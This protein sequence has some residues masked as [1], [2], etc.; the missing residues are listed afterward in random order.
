MSPIISLLPLL[1]PPAVPPAP[2][3]VAHP[4]SCECA[5]EAHSEDDTTA[6]A[7]AVEGEATDAS[8]DLEAGT[9]EPAVAEDPFATDDDLADRNRKL[10]Q[11]MQQGEQKMIL[12]RI[13]VAAGGTLFL[14]GLG[15]TVAGGVL[16]NKPAL[17]VGI[18]L[19]LIGAAGAGVST[20][21]AIRGHREVKEAQAGNLSFW[22]DRNG[23]GIVWSGRF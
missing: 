1:A 22:G 6:D 14:G 9:T 15:A 10:S 5:A 2:L 21:F 3:V 11:K 16:K 19:M 4:H 12:G 20:V 13:G 18:P 8:T 23:G 7:E 17:G